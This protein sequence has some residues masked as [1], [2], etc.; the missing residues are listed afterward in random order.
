MAMK[1][2]E[3][4]I[5]PIAPITDDT[6]KLARW[7]GDLTRTLQQN[8]ATIARKANDSDTVPL[9]GD[10]DAAGFDIFNVGELTAD[11]G[12]FNTSLTV[13]GVAVDP[14]AYQPL[15][16]D[17]TSWAAI[18][19]AAGFDTFAAAAS[20]ANFLS[21][22]T[23]ETGTGF[24]VFSASPALTGTPTAPT[25]AP[26]TNTTQ[27]ATTAF[28]ATSFAP[29]A[30]PALTGNPTAP[31]AAPG[32]NDTT[33]ATTAFVTAAVGAAATPIFTE[34]FDSGNQTITSAGA[35]TL[36]H[37]LSSQPKLY[38]AFLKNTTAEK[39]YSIG[40][41][42]LIST[43]FGA[44]ENRGVSLVPDATNI[45]VRFASGVAVFGIQDK[46]TGAV[47]NATNAN[48]ALVVRAWA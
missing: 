37:G 5:L 32:D 7:A 40:D 11:V 12:T 28:V 2:P 3:K 9:T 48:W 13:N 44:A 41:E 36:A 46:N 26:G 30:S 29:L 39:N 16:A 24:V 31:T 17:L 38:L 43:H 42:L 8:L 34:A 25:A 23:D 19:R 20:S 22:L 14:T 21:M 4:Q 18:T 27:L 35:L 10:L 33:I 6:M 45:N 1:T 15:D 47:S